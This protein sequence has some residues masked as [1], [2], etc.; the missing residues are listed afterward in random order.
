MC[1]WDIESAATLGT[2]RESKKSSNAYRPVKQTDGQA[3]EIIASA[4]H[5]SLYVI[6]GSFFASNPRP[7]LPPKSDPIVAAT[8]D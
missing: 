1:V 8:G 7:G 6:I 5:R 4:T 2:L 3:S